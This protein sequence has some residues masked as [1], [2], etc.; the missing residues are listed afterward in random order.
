[1]HYGALVMRRSLSC[2]LGLGL[3][4]SAGEAQAQSVRFTKGPYLQGLGSTGATVRWEGSEPLGGVVQVKG[5]AGFSR[6]FPTEVKSAF[7]TLEI[8]GLTAGTSY[9]YSVKIGD[10]VSPEGRFAT[11]PEGGESLNFI[12]YGDNRTDHRAHQAVVQAMLG[13]PADFL[14][15]TGDMV[16][17]GDNEADWS[18]FFEIE[19]PLLRDR[20]LFACIGNHEMIGNHPE[21]YLRY[22]QAGGSSSKPTL[23]YS[24]RWGNARFFFLNAFA[25]WASGPDRTWL[26]QE[27]TRADTEAGLDHRFVIMHHGPYSSGYHGA[28]LDFDRPGL[29]AFLAQHRVTMVFAGHDHVYERGERDGLRY[30]LSGGGGA[31]LY[32]VTQ[33][34]PEARAIETVNHFVEVKIEGKIVKTNARRV[35]GSSMDACTLDAAGWRCEST[36]PPL[37]VAPATSP[38]NAKKRACDCVVPAGGAEGGEGA[39]AV[40]LAIGLLLCLRR[41]RGVS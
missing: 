4:V 26:E 31:P 33:A 27:L 7:H 23:F 32:K 14:L 37:P 11:A 24:M 12:L 9:T 29:P 16:A 10:L 19:G 28:N 15:N 25:S 17:E 8:A 2:A 34:R 20:C 6:E 1:M 38:D 35:D 30:I 41:A 3:L 13:V 18:R 36:T 21:R 22:F 40:G 39:V 5:P